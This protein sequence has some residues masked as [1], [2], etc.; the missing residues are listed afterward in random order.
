MTPP[1][2]AGGVVVSDH[3]HSRVWT[4]VAITGAVTLLLGL[5]LIRFYRGVLLADARDRTTAQLAPYGQALS[6]TMGHRVAVLQGFEAFLRLRT[7][8]PGV[9][10]ELQRYTDGLRAQTD[11]IRALQL[12]RDGR[13]VTIAPLEGN[14]AALG[15][16][17]RQHPS[18]EVRDDLIRAEASGE[19]LVTGPFP[20][21]Q[22]GSGL[23]IRQRLP[24]RATV[25]IELASLV[26][27]LPPILEESGLGNVAGVQWVLRDRHGDP[28]WGDTTI[29]GFDP[30]TVSVAVP[31][32][33]WRLEAIPT[34]GWDTAIEA[35]LWA[36]GTWVALSCLLICVVA[37][38][39]AAR[40]ASLE[41]AVAE[42]TRSLSTTLEALQREVEERERAESQLGQLQRLESLGRMAGGIAHDFNNLLTVILTSI[43]LARDEAARGEE[44][45][46]DLET[47]ER[48][49]TRAS[50]LTKK[51]LVFARRQNVEPQVVDL[52]DVVRELRPILGR[53]LSGAV[54]IDDLQADLW[55]VFIDPIQ[56]EQVLSNL[57]VNARDAMPQGGSMYLR[58]RN[59]TMREGTEGEDLPPGEYVLLEVQD[60]GVGMPPE[61]LQMV[62]EPFF[63]TKGAGQGTGLG[64]PTVYGIV[65]KAGGSIR[66]ISAPGSGTTVRIHLPRAGSDR[67]LRHG[68]ARTVLPS[69]AGTATIL[70]VEDE[71]EVR[72]V[73]ERILVEAGYTVLTAEEG[74]RALTLLAGGRRV[75][76]LIADVVTPGMGGR[77]LAERVLEQAPGTR[78]LFISGYT[79]DEPLEG[80]LG[81]PGVAFLAKP[82]TVKDLKESVRRLLDGHPVRP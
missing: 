38:L 75:D 14:E 25:P 23:V 27:D 69:K 11:G 55:P 13:I 53:M 51:L 34:G 24:R 36:L 64:L 10:A 18:A 31:G 3:R 1:A 17:L 77:V 2:P 46:E 52:N 33:P 80:L 76:L 30:V 16:D 15:L 68:S 45:A 63:T 49:T 57:V 39:V 26:L 35:G 72:L 56:L 32:R 67:A 43:S 41:A 29:A 78:V 5:G 48:A 9:D 7:L 6:A 65:R 37:Y 58:T 74:G 79:A 62:F 19:I 50:E 12:V 47:A 20:L 8:V 82:F 70:L 40:Q 81:R 60:S 59:V 28:I 44:I 54:L 66:L 73:T 22:G 42:R 61:I 21:I 71:L 4:V